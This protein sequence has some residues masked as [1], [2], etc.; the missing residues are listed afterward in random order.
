MQARGDNGEGAMEVCTY[1]YHLHLSREEQ[2][3]IN[4]EEE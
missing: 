2:E 4:N 3:G 1:L